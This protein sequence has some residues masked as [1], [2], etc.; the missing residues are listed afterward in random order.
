MLIGVGHALSERVPVQPGVADLAVTGEVDDDL[1]VLVEVVVA[2]RTSV[3]ARL[4]AILYG[5]R[6]DSSVKK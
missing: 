4:P 3:R 5:R 1:L 6:A 2:P